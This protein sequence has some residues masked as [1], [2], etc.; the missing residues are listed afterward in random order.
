MSEKT[1]ITLSLISHTNVGK[2]TLARTLL[3]RDVGEVRD[4]DHVTLESSRHL[5]LENADARLYIW[6]NPG[7]GGTHGKKLL[8]RIRN[9]GSI[10]GWFFHQVVDRF[11]N[12]SLYSSLE[13]ARNLRSHADV[14]LYLVD[15]RLHPRQAGYVGPEIEL[16]RELG[17][18][19]LV[20]VNQLQLVS[21]Q[22]SNIPSIE[23]LWNDYLQ[24]LKMDAHVFVLDAFSR[25]WSQ[26]LKV[27]EAIITLLSPDLKPAME[28]L[29]EEYVAR[30]NNIL[31]RCAGCASEV[32]TFAA[33]QR[34]PGA[35]GKN[36]KEIFAE[37]YLGL[38]S[39]LDTYV[40]CLMDQYSL[41]ASDSPELEADLQQVS[42]LS[43]KSLPE[44]LV[45]LVTAAVSGAGGGLAADIAAGGLTFGGGA[46][47]GFLLGGVGG[48]AAARGINYF[49]KSDGDC[50]W[51]SDFLVTLYRRLMFY[52]LLVAHHGRGKGLIE[53]KQRRETWS[54]ALEK[55]FSRY[56]QRAERAV[57]SMQAGVNSE[58]VSD[59]LRNIFLEVTSETLEILYPEN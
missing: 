3:K 57:A 32:L 1:G 30:Q 41:E 34:L 27:L 48:L 20:L 17:K 36:N 51:H 6:D 21:E 9:E 26:E 8:K 40:E 33:G 7:F 18:P 11:S 55:A 54:T 46:L 22:D 44:N 5:M 14:V 28:G 42:G 43:P 24:E 31:F 38:Q 53:F 52:H 4:Q 45:G 13:A 50:R 59:D 25:Y 16:I 10:G 49:L 56:E 12:R 15:A 47:I 29:K 58:K 23:K 35:E 37:L 2:T 39:R 19:I